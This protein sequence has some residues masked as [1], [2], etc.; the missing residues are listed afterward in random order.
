MQYFHM[1]GLSWDVIQTLAVAYN[2]HPLS[3]EDIV[4]IPQRIKTDF[5]EEY[6][7]TSVLLLSVDH[8]SNLDHD[9]MQTEVAAA[10]AVKAVQAVREEHAAAAL[11]G[12]AAA[13]GGA[14]AR[15]AAAALQRQ[16]SLQR[17]GSVA[18]A[19]VEAAAK[20]PHLHR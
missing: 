2:L 5:Y 3:V 7:Y 12:A 6:L 18:A 9:V 19:A 17:T 20:Q 13:A 11:P 16:G 14:A 10:A 1:Q 8:P 4:H 15:A